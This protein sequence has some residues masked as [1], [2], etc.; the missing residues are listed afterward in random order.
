MAAVKL[1]E[2]LPEAAAAVL[3]TA[4]HDVAL[5][6]DQKLAGALDDRLL[7]VASAEGRALVTLDLGI[8]NVRRHPPAGTAGIIVLRLKDHAVP[9]I[10]T[11]MAQLARLLDQEPTSGRLW[12]LTES[13]L[14]IWPG[15]S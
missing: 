10:K 15:G 3:R 4:G 9:S 13:R 8:G 12:V 7:A 2:N 14:R 6:R 5:A 1:D 11:V